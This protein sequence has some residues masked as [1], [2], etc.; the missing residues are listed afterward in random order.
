MELDVPAS[1]RDVAF[2]P[3]AGTGEAVTENLLKGVVMKTIRKEEVIEIR[4]YAALCSLLML[5][6]LLPLVTMIKVA[7]P[8]NE[9]EDW[10]GVIMLAAIT[11]GRH[12]YGM[13]LRIFGTAPS[14]KSVAMYEMLSVGAV[15]V[16]LAGLYLGLRIS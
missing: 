15:A 8:R 11:L 10:V 2:K 1:F 13:F 5:M 4:G 16:I 3:N 7:R 6:S 14:R 12:V 9:A